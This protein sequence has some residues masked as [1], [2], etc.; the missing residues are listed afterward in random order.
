[1]EGVRTA[2]PRWVLRVHVFWTVYSV[3][4]SAAS[5][6][7]G[8]RRAAAVRKVGRRIVLGIGSNSVRLKSEE[9]NTGKLA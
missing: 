3:V 4:T 8:R 6:M 9:K 7:R 2:S 5:A 1:M